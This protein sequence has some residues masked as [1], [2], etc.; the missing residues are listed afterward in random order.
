MYIREREGEGE[1]Q[2]LGERRVC[3][4]GVEK[5]RVY[6]VGCGEYRLGGSNRT[7]LKGVVW[8]AG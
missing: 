5:D 7:V 1:G 8:G 2:V 6:I 3:I 4:E